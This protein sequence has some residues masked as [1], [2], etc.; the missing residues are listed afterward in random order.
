VSKLSKHSGVIVG[1][2]GSP[3][4]K[5][6]VQWAAR[7]AELRNVP[8]TLV[9]VVPA[10]AGTWLE[11][12]LVPTWMG[13]QRE[14]GRQVLDEA[15]KIAGKSC[16]R[17]ETQIECEMPSSITVPAL[18]DM[19]KDAD[20]V[21]VGCLGT[22][23]LRGRH[24]GSVS[25]GL[26]YH[27]HCP[28]AVIH[29]GV[30]VTADAARAPVLLG[31]DGSPESELATAIAFDEAS[32]R[33]VELVALHAW[34]PVGVFDTIVSL[35]GPGWPALRA[36]EDEVLAERLAGW[37]ERYP[38]VSVQ[39]HIVRDEPARQLVET[40]EWAQ[41]VVVGSHGRGGFA[42]MLLGSVSAAVVLL[43]RVPVIVAR[44]PLA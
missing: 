37:A 40:S 30:E 3:G 12:S 42:G 2:D 33:K 8:L 20:L 7:D 41:L 9:H 19:S 26:V 31:I 6:A 10:T 43:A 1:V 32:R 21:V 39:R 35:P 27:A 16:Q 24:L 5:F 29:D 18:V 4:S 14:R 25:S 17:G 23:T 36:V 15:L 34:S 22:G 28:V 38:D 13:A 11:S 44:E